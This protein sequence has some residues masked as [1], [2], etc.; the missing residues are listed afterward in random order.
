MRTSTLLP[1]I[2]LLACGD[3]SDP[4]TN[5]S[6]STGASAA[7]TTAT[8]T[9]TVTA[10]NTAT[11]TMTATGTA[12]DTATDTATAT[13]TDTATD[14]ASGNTTGEATDGATETGK[15]TGTDGETD[16][17]GSTGSTGMDVTTGGEQGANIYDI[18]NGVYAENTELE[19]IGVTVTG[20]RNNGFYAQEPAGGA[21]SGVWV[22]GGNDFQDTWGVLAVGDN[23][24]F[25]GLYIEFNDLTEIDVSTSVAPDITILGP[26]VEIVPE[27]VALADLADAAVAETWEGVLIQTPAV[28]VTD[29]DLGFGEWEVGD[30]TDAVRIDDQLWAYS[31]FAGLAVDDPFGFVA[32]VVNFSFG[33][34]KLEPRTDADFDGAPPPPPG[35]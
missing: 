6:G 3:D 32:G 24:S 34:Y 17:S 35:L 22:Y 1:L 10:T 23:V 4:A 14:T 28:T 9:A 2:L 21:Y 8:V 18:Q 11:A 7:T 29:P 5:A 27:E 20:V 13:A 16:S 33:N 30:G 12:T 26:G 15:A 25:A 19:V 31:G